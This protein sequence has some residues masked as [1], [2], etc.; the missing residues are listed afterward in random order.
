MKIAV[1]DDRREDREELCTMLEQYGVLRGLPVKITCY[2]SGEELLRNYQPGQYQCIFLD[3]YMEGRD[4][5]EIAG[6]VYRLDPACRLIFATV[7]LTHAVSSYEVRAAWYLTKP[8][9]AARLA[10]AMDTVCQGMQHSVR[11]LTVHL[12]GA[13][14]P[15]RYSDIYYIDCAERQARIYLRDK[16]IEADEPISELLQCLADD[17]RF[18]V[19]N[20]N[21]A[22][23]MD[24]VELAEER[25]FRMKNGACVPMRQ[26]GRAALK[27]TYLVWSLQELRQ[28]NRHGQGES[29]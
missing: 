24:H 21:T 4:G 13:A 3:I 10:D 29:L 5:M 19:C 26:R 15:V 1:V 18:L 7:S 2:S 28:T 22:V 17:S 23:N 12:R 8:Y 9:N 27:K 25:D 6:E 11:I 20:R 16:M 14:L